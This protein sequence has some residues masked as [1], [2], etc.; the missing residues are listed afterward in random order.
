MGFGEM[1]NSDIEKFLLAVKLIKVL[2]LKDQHSNIPLPHARLPLRGTSGQV[3]GVN[4][5]PH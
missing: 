1:G 2:F 5:K 3:L 4:I